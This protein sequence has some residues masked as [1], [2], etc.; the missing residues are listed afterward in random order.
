M[1]TEYKMKLAKCL[2][3]MHMTQTRDNQDIDIVDSL[4]YAS[5][6][7]EVNIFELSRNVGLE[8]LLKGEEE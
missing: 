4:Q 7:A 1:S 6:T 3:E 2:F 8:G 5:K